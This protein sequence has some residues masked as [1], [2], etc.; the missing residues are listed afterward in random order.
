[1]GEDRILLDLEHGL[2][3]QAQGRR[4]GRVL[5]RRRRPRRRHRRTGLHRQ[6]RA[7]AAGRPGDRR[8]A[9]QAG[10][11]HARRDRRQ[12]LPEPARG[13]DHLGLASVSVPLPLAPTTR[14]P[15]MIQYAPRPETFAVPTPPVVNP[16]HPLALRTAV[17]GGSIC[18]EP[19]AVSPTTRSLASPQ[20][21]TVTAHLTARLNGYYSI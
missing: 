3:R 13:Q 17:P 12:H 4:A 21:E 5:L 16:S 18:N 11:L 20:F 15:F 6:Y 10:V 14:L 1:M 7:G 9:R 8:A 2:A 19:D